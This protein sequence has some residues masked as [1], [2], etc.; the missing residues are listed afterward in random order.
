M[1]NGIVEKWDCINYGGEW[2]NPYLHFD[3]TLWSLLTLFTIQTTEGWIG[4]MWTSTDAVG[5]D[6]QP[7]PNYNP[8]MV[9]VFVILV[10]IISMLFLNLFVGV[11]IETFNVEKGLLTY[12]Q[13]L[14]PSQKSWIDV[15][16]M[17]YSAKPS[18]KIVATGSWLRDICISVVTHQY[19]DG[20]IMGCIIGNTIV[21]AIKWYMMAESIVSVIEIINYVFCVIFTL[22]AIFKI[23]AMRKNYFKE[24]WNIF[25]FTVVVLTAVILGL[26]FGGVGGNLGV[27][28]TILRSLRIGRVFRL[29][30]KA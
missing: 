12:N 29:V 18:L 14:K 27:T 3:D 24:N 9:I 23:T 25:D 6:L 10:I 2:Q 16:I 30:K 22:E 21:L 28:S 5:V 26:Q 7:I 1:K 19:F 4:V 11:V 15:Q 17:T 13:L 20:F 8:Y